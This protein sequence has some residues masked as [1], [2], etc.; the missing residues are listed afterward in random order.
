MLMESA[1][2]HFL[3]AQATLFVVGSVQALITASYDDRYGAL[4]GI[5]GPQRA[6]RLSDA[7]ESNKMVQEP[8]EDGYVD[9]KEIYGSSEVY[10]SMSI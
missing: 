9:A 5:V 4:A 3:A 1:G 7:I 10:D 8:S 2:M 6:K